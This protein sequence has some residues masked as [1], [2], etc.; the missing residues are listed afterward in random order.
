MCYRNNSTKDLESFADAAISINRMMQQHLHMSLSCQPSHYFHN[1]SLD[2]GRARTDSTSTM[3]PDSASSNSSNDSGGSS[4][5]L[6]SSFLDG[7]QSS[8][9]LSPPGGSRLAKRRATLHDCGMHIT[10]AAK[11]SGDSLLGLSDWRM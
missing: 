1:S 6:P 4:E 9:R 11:G 3:A 2:G 7:F 10:Q 5:D 8:M